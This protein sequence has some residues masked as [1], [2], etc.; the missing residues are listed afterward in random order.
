MS[1]VIDLG[2]C[3]YEAKVL[4]IGRF[5]VESSP[6]SNRDMH[7]KNFTISSR[8]ERRGYI[9]SYVPVVKLYRVAVA[10]TRASI[11]EL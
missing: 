1:E 2:L 8:A 6:A 5:P 9:L 11:T 4:Y 10:V 7:T 3:Y